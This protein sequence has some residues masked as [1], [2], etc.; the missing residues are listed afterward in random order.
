MS[1][2]IRPLAAVYWAQ[3]AA[4]AAIIA[5]AALG[6][7]AATLIFGVVFIALWIGPVA[8][9]NRLEAAIGAAAGEVSRELNPPG[10]VSRQRRRT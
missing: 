5:T 3:A 6:R 2:L 8:E 10:T 9:A 4:V 7:L 1:A